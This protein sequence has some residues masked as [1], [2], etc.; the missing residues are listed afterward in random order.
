MNP[1][2][3][4][5]YLRIV[6]SLGQ[7]PTLP[8]VVTKVHQVL[9][10]PNSGAGHAA[11]II[12][13]DPS[14]ASKVLKIAN[15]SYYGIPRTIYNIQSAIALLGFNTVKTLV[16]SSTALKALPKNARC[17]HFDYKVFWKH[18]VEVAVIARFLAR[19]GLGA[20]DSELAFTAGLLHDIGKLIF[21][22]SLSED[23]EKALEKS[24]SENQEL[25]KV[26]QELLGIHHAELSGLLLEHWGIPESLQGPLKYQY[27]PELGGNCSPLAFVIHYA[28]YLSHLSGTNPVRNEPMPELNPAAADS[29]GLTTTPEEMLSLLEGELEY[30]T[31]FLHLIQL[32]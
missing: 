14:L 24:I 10:H 16:L 15:S 1:E 12:E 27:N 20:L 29:I 19:T 5:K 3:Q 23:W 13:T 6:D 26:E 21:D 32:D 8:V 18:S 11:K 17:P 28:N 31:E 30:V 4:Q 2:V 22:E 25:Y 7:V 9:S